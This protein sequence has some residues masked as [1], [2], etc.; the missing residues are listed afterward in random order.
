MNITDTLKNQ[1][2][3]SLMLLSQVN[4]RAGINMMATLRHEAKARKAKT[5]DS[6][7]GDTYIEDQFADCAPQ[8]P[9][10]VPLDVSANLIGAS[11]LLSTEQVNPDYEFLKRN[12]RSPKQII[13]SQMD[14]IADQEAKQRLATAQKFGLQVSVDKFLKQIKG[15]QQ[16]SIATFITE[17]QSALDPSLRSYETNDLIT[18]IEETYNN[19][20]WKTMLEDS[21]ISLYESAAKRIEDGKFADLPDELVEFAQSVLKTRGV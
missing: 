3:V 11:L 12:I 15:Q 1:D 19:K 7:R 18:I 6:I 5:E 20:D 16:E 13:I 10:I 17:A 2:A 4:F 9:S 14:W 21:I 8:G